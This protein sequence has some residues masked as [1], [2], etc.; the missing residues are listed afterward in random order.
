[1]VEALQSQQQAIK[2][3][4]N[5]GVYRSRQLLDQDAAARNT[6]VARIYSDLGFEKLAITEGAKALS[7]APDNFSA[8]RFM[9]D[10]N[11]TQPKRKR[12]VDSD[13]LQSKLLAPLNAH[14]LRP[15][16]S[17][18]QLGDGPARFS[19][20]EFNPLFTRSGPSLLLDGFVAGNNTWGE[21]AIASYLDNRF[22]ISLAQYHYESDGFRDLDW[23][24]KDTLTAF[25]QLDF[26][27]ET[28]IQIE[29]SD[30]KQKN[31]DLN[32]HFFLE[33][34]L[35]EFREDTD[36]EMRRFG[37]RHALSLNS[38]L[39]G[40]YS[41]VES[42]SRTTRS[43]FD[44]Q[45]T[46]ED[47]DNIEIQWLLVAERSTLI[48]GGNRLNRKESQDTII[49]F[50]GFPDFI[51]TLNSDLEY[52]NYYLYSYIPL[53]PDLEFTLA[54]SYSDDKVKRHTID[55][56][57]TV[58][59]S[60]DD[61]QFN[62][63]L[64]IVW[65]ISDRSTIRVAAFRDRP[66]I[67]S[68][69]TLEPTQIA[70]F[71]QIYDDFQD[72]LVTD[73][74]R[75]GLGFDS[76]LKPDLQFGFSAL[77]SDLKGKIYGATVDDDELFDMNRFLF[78]A[79]VYSKTISDLL[80]NIE[81]EFEKY[82]SPETMALGL[83]LDSLETHR[84]PITLRYFFSKAFSSSLTSTYYNQEGIY[85]GSIEG[86]DDFWIIDANIT[87]N[88]PRRLGKI[89]IGAKNLLD[90]DFNY[91]DKQNNTFFNEDQSSNI[92]ELSSER[93]IYGKFSVNF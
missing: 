12:A 48:I 45:K 87:Y 50:P 91:E 14:T 27:P 83:R 77:Y 78:N 39:L 8:H 42:E 54:S 92:N 31:G 33:D 40:N 68:T 43:S 26:T 84:L 51:T 15:E 4:D 72:T 34:N 67:A 88:L 9:A 69:A 20:N 93:I 59:N 82:E 22:S 18:L 58:E 65:D 85:D 24:E 76:K 63:K 37:F 49:S 79:Y 53:T 21:D 16:L 5:R 3:N 19:Y 6:A 38:K 80:L 11:A 41:S 1:P 74:K 47:N 62:P 2:L 28:M 30:D 56:L 23:L 44:S 60:D 35:P 73:A 66:L 32:Q 25:A 90:S 64:G 86:K 46:D 52:N 29:Y 70:G 7:Q 89:S 13:L 55:F 17:D 10:I 81:Y 75:F 57:G 61:S 71:N 36:K